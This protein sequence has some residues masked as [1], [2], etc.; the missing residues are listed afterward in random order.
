MESKTSQAVGWVL[1]SGHTVGSSSGLGHHTVPPGRA[2]SPGKGSRD[3][4]A[5]NGLSSPAGPG[6]RQSTQFNS[7]KKG[8]MWAPT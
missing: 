7:Q 2:Q 5:A 4:G 6:S 3:T 8:M 1:S